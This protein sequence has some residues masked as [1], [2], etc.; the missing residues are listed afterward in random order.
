MNRLRRSAQLPDF[1]G[2][3]ALSGYPYYSPLKEQLKK[4]FLNQINSDGLHHLT[5]A[6]K[7]KNVAS[8]ELKHLAFFFKNLFYMV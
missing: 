7:E 1:A 5:Q 3:P 8:S 2:C 4:S 6:I